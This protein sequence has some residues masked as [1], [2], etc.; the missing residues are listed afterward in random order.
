MIVSFRFHLQNKHQI[1]QTSQ[2]NHKT[3][4]YEVPIEDEDEVEASGQFETVHT[5]EGTLMDGHV[6]EE[7]YFIMEDD[8][9]GVEEGTMSDLIVKTYEV[10]NEV[11]VEA[12]EDSL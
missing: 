2:S 6:L 11:L 4:S 1:K 7:E 9:V 3:E 8:F 12:I 10:Q 5:E